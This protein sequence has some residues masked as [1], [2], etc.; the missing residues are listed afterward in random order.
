MLTVVICNALVVKI[1]SISDCTELLRQPAKF[2]V[3]GSCDSHEVRLCFLCD[4]HLIFT[5]RS[6]FFC[7]R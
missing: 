7:G 4:S 5:W 6:P 2:S 1:S 3:N